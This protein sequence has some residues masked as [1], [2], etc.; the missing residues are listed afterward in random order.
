MVNASTCRHMYPLRWPVGWI[1]TDRP[2]RS[3]FSRDRTMAGAREF[4]LGELGRL[5]V[6]PGTV[7]ISSNAP[8]GKNGFPYSGQPQPAEKGVALYF[9]ILGTN[10]VLACD[11]WDRVEDNLYVIGKHVE[12]MR[13]QTRY[14]VGSMVQAMQAYKALPLPQ[15]RHCNRGYWFE[16]LGVLET[17]TPEEIEAAFRERA[18]SVHLDRG[19]SDEQMSLLNRARELGLQHVGKEAR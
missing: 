8:L 2:R 19:G 13:A 15:V 9:R 1:C 16:I 18:L 10:H 11:R 5:K 4:I 12:A 7:E 17:A 14:G 6:D 3:Y